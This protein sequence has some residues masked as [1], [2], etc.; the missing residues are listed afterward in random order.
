MTLPANDVLPKHDELA[1]REL[2]IEEL[3]AI[4]AG[5]PHWLKA[6]VHDVGNWIKSEVNDYVHVRV[7]AAESLVSGTRDLLRSIF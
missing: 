2:S 1:N 7:V 3:E 4:A 5:W 6:A